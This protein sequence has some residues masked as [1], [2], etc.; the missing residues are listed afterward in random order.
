VRQAGSGPGSLVLG[1]LRGH[2]C[3]EATCRTCGGT[4][5]LVSEGV[6]L[7]LASLEDE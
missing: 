4:E 5:M 1:T 6:D 7:L 3:I 2:T